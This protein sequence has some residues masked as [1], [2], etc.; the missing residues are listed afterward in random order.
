MGHSI[1]GENFECKKHSGMKLRNVQ[2]FGMS[3]TKESGV[4][5]KWGWR[6]NVKRRRIQTF[7]EYLLKGVI[8]I[9]GRTSLI[10][11]HRQIPF[12]NQE[13]FPLCIFILSCLHLIYSTYYNHTRIVKVTSVCRPVSASLWATS[14][15]GIYPVLINRCSTNVE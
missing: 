10:S 7:I 4:I 11:S 2:T 6:H 3:G 8:A 14:D 1:P 12:P 9:L 5:R 13:V 15:S